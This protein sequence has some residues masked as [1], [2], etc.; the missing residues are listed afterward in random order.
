MHV[1]MCNGKDL[2]LSLLQ[3]G[4]DHLQAVLEAHCP[5]ICRLHIHK[6]IGCTSWPAPHSGVTLVL[7]TPEYQGLPIAVFAASDRCSDCAQA[8]GDCCW[9]CPGVHLV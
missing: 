1:G 7:G 3:L 5:L 9:L 4:L 8:S 6:H 2:V